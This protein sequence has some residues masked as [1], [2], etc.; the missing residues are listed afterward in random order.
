MISGFNQFNSAIKQLRGE[1]IGLA[2]DDFGSG[3]SNFE[4]LLRLHVDF[5]KIDG[6]LIKNIDTDTNAY[7]TVK[8]IT[9]FA[10]NLGISVVAE[11]VHSEEVLFKVKELPQ[12]H[13]RKRR[14][15][16]KACYQTLGV[17]L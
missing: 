5:I 4:Y 7:T 1:G 11:F 3:Y 16:E 15:S 14:S 9:H 8:A 13:I 12:C 10:K 6:S 2:I 17:S